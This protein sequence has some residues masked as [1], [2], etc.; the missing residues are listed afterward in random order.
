MN[1][2][3]TPP[4]ELPEDHR[5]AAEVLMDLVGQEAWVLIG[6]S[7]NALP[8]PAPVAPATSAGTFNPLAGLDLA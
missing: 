2:P 4:T 7:P 6:L 1:H 3:Y 5:T 8:Q